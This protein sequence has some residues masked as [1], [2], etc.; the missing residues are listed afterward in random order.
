VGGAALVAQPFPRLRLIVP[1]VAVPVMSLVH[2]L[3]LVGLIAASRQ[4]GIVADPLTLLTPGALYDAVLGLFIGP[5]VVVI[6]D[7]RGATERPDW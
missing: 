7:R 5:L 6:H 2:S 1:I 3:V 4:G